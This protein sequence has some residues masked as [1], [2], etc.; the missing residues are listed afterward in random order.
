MN[1]D[2]TELLQISKKAAV[3]AGREILKI[4]H[5]DDFDVEL[6]GDNSPLT[7]ADKRAHEV[8]VDFLSQTDIPVLSEEG[9][10]IPFKIR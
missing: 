5:S 2:K 7:K 8:I 3:E 9:S 6:K 10:D 1:I 4:Y